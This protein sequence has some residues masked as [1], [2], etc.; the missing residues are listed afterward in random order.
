MLK[1]LY[2]DNYKCLVNFTFTPKNINL[3]LGENGTG[4]STVFEVLSILKYFITDGTDLSSFPSDS[5]TRWQKTPIQNFELSVSLQERNYR[6]KLTI[7]HYHPQFRSRIQLEQLFVDEQLLFDFQLGK[8]RLFNDDFSAGPNYPFHWLRPGLATI[9]PRQD[10]QLLTTF[11]NWIQN[12]IVIKPN[13]VLMATE[14]KKEE[15]QLSW[16]GENFSS[17]YRYLSQE[18]QAEAFELT[19]KLREIFTGFHSFRLQQTGEETRSL[20][21][22]FKAENSEIIFYRLDELS[23]GQRMIVLLY[24]L[25][26]SHGQDNVCLCIDE[27]ENFLALPEIQPWLLNLYDLCQKRGIQAFLISH[28]PEIINYLASGSGYWL[29]RF[30]NSPTRIK[31]IVETGDTGLKI[32]ELI[33]R[34]WLYE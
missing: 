30:P 26:Y 24:A 1:E 22:G 25:L 7:E 13:P 34:G 11:K 31:P 29:D 18:R 4:K 2:I 19:Q 8:I 14:S 20:Q 27:P 23:D 3:L 5:L 15:P 21:L 33:A 32:S 9:N 6:Y 12:L 28:N 10:N 17:W 16:Y